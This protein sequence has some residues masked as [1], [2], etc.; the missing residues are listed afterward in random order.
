MRRYSIIIRLRGRSIDYSNKVASLYELH[1]TREEFVIILL[2]IT[3]F[4]KHNNYAIRCG[5]RSTC[6]MRNVNVNVPTIL[7]IEHDIVQSL[8]IARKVHTDG[9]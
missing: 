9:V 5:L 4:P 1:N 8:R 7:C 6:G 2:E 3:A